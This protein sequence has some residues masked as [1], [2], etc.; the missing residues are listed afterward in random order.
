MY[1]KA[2]K[3]ERGIKMNN[4]KNNHINTPYGKVVANQERLG[5]E[6]FSITSENKYIGKT[7]IGLVLALAL[8]AGGYNW[9]KS[10][11]KNPIMP[12]EGYM[13]KTMELQVEDGIIWNKCAEIYNN[14]YTNL[15]PSLNDYVD[16][17]LEQNQISDRLVERWQ[18][19]TFPVI[20]KEDNPHFMEATALTKQIDDL[21]K[22]EEGW[23]KHKVQ[24]GDSL[25]KYGSFYSKDPNIQQH[26]R[27]LISDANP[28]ISFKNLQ[29]GDTV[30]LP[31]E[32]VMNLQ[33]A[34][35]AANEAFLADIL[36][37]GNYTK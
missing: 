17:V 8:L 14:Q 12:P 9:G 21:L 1:N 18:K 16:Y 29:I 6:K 37:K 20:F 24:S 19:V 15:Y 26:Y 34:L 11:G 2:R 31:T 27:I 25:H 33:A 30:T 5:N 36:N 3:E 10:N 7:I 28:E 35:E 4:N 32:Q 13:M 22:S 23:M